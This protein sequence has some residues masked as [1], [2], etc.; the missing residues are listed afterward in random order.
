MRARTV[1]PACSGCE[2]CGPIISAEPVYTAIQQRD[3]NRTNAKGTY[4]NSWRIDL[5][6]HVRR[7]QHPV[8]CAAC[9]QLNLSPPELEV[10]E[11]DLAVFCDSNYVRA[12][13]LYLSGT[14]RRRLNAIAFLQRG[15][16]HCGD[17]LGSVAPP[18]A[19]VAQHHT[20][21]RYPM[22]LVRRGFGVIGRPCRTSVNVLLRAGGIGPWLSIRVRCRL[23][24]REHLR[25]GECYG[26]ESCPEM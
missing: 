9:G 21:P 24:L 18:D 25:T 7:P 15:V 14:G 12:V 23:E 10:G 19:H 4:R 6:I 5:Y 2:P 3:T 16:H 20:E 13:D 11:P 8:E 1:A 26:K 17:H 22:L